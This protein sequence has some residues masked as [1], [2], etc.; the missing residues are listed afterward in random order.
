MN[1]RCIDSKWGALKGEI[2]QPHFI[3]LSEPYNLVEGFEHRCASLPNGGNRLDNMYEWT[4]RNN[5]ARTQASLSQ[6]LHN[7]DVVIDRS[8]LSDLGIFAQYTRWGAYPT[9]M[10]CTRIG[11]TVF[12]CPFDEAKKQHFNSDEQRLLSYQLAKFVQLLTKGFDARGAFTDRTYHHVLGTRLVNPDA[13]ARKSVIKVVY[14]SQIYALEAF[15]SENPIEFRCEQ[16]GAEPNYKKYL[17]WY[18]QARFSGAD[19]MLVGIKRD[20]ALVGIR[21]VPVEWLRQSAEANGSWKANI[22]IGFLHR[23]LQ[24]ICRRV[25]AMAEGECLIVEHEDGK[26]QF[27]CQKTADHATSMFS[28]RFLERYA[29]HLISK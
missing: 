27:K 5:R 13:S 14:P 19:T 2:A 12:I 3:E 1:A 4:T 23:F 8:T 17:K 24:E 16:E 29:A 21:V 28:A 6:V 9:R 26:R 25:R 22:S 10:A 20:N 11:N 18:L 15:N 7:T